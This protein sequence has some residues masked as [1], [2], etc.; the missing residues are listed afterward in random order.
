[1]SSPQVRVDLGALAKAQLQQQLGK[2]G[3]ELKKKLQDKLQDL[4]K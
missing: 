3:D 4:L 2:H 1:M